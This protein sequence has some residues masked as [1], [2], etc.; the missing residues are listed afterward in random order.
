MLCTNTNEK[1]KKKEIMYDIHVQSDNADS[2]NTVSE[3]AHSELMKWVT[4]NV[5]PLKQ[6]YNEYLQSFCQIVT[7][8]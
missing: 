8:H 4:F 2:V 3:M 5:F 7:H 1:R 6:R